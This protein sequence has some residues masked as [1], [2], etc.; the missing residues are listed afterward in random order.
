MIPKRVVSLLQHLKDPSDL[1]ITRGFKGG[2][3]V[4]TLS[5]VRPCGRGV[6]PREPWTCLEVHTLTIGYLI[7]RYKRNE[8]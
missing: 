7:S 5:T 2:G 8:Y 3:V 6:L 4:T 1:G